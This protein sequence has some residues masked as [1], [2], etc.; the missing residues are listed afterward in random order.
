[1]YVVEARAA[2]AAALDKLAGLYVVKAVRNVDGTSGLACIVDVTDVLAPTTACPPGQVLV[3]VIVWPAGYENGETAASVLEAG[4][5]QLLDILTRTIG[6]TW[7][8]AS[9]EEF[10]DVGRAC[11]I[12][13]EVT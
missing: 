6:L 4:L 10:A 3:D 13:I 2:V 8:T 1:M 11:R 5:D 9:F 7:R 12:T